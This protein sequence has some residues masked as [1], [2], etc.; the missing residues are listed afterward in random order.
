MSGMI[1][2]RIS[3]SQLDFIDYAVL[4]GRIVYSDRKPSIAEWRRWC[5]ELVQDAKFARE[6]ERAYLE[7]GNNYDRIIDEQVRELE[8]LRGLVLAARSAW[9]VGLALGWAGAALFVAPVAGHYL[10]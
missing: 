6:R 10:G 8:R 9:A 3:D 7:D 5:R 2:R 1:A 4:N